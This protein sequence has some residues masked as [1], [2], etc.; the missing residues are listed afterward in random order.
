MMADLLY[1]SGDYREAVAFYEKLVSRNPCEEEHSCRLMESLG[2]LRKYREIEKVFV[3]LKKNLKKELN[4]E[5]QTPTI[6]LYRSLIQSAKT[7]G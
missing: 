3:K 1:R 7:A 6:E 4:E 5:P 2:Q